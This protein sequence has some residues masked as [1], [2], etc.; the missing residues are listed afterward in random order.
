MA[1][2]YAPT[3]PLNTAPTT[4]EAYRMSKAN[5]ASKPPTQP[6]SVGPAPGTVP[7]TPGAAGAYAPGVSLT[8]TN[9]NNDLRSQ[10]ITPG[11]T[12][13]RLGVANQYL[14]NWQQSTE[15]QYQADLRS[16][17]QQA[18]GAGQLGSGQLRT[19]L[20]DLAYNRN[21]QDQ[22]QAS[23][24]YN[25]ALNNSIQDAYNNVG[26]AQQQQAF[27]AG[28]QNQTFNQGATA[29]Q[30]GQQGNPSQTL[31]SLAGY[32]GNQANGTT[33][34]LPGLYT[35]GTQAGATNATT[36]GLQQYLNSLGGYGTPTSPVGT[37]LYNTPT[38]YGGY[39]S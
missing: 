2:P 39:T 1:S 29:V 24:F 8:A 6:L 37:P 36:Q 34:G 7:Y 22:T 23:N 26:I 21:L 31:L 5:G 18:A 17:T 3:T 32:Y 9:P 27:Q 38:Y 28:L 4:F 25:T 15:P 19:S 12:A 30:L 20:G 11:P 10:T 33:A 35:A 16:A 14:Q 13:S